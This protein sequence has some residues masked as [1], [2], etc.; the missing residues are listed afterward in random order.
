MDDIKFDQIS[1]LYE[2]LQGKCPEGIY[3]RH[4]PRLSR[5]KAFS[6]IWFL[7]EHLRILPDNFEQCCSCKDL[8]DANREGGYY[9]DRLYCDPCYDRK[10]L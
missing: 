1:E 6:V 2:F 4:P 5:R 7:Q 9:R 3:I 8:Y 10:T